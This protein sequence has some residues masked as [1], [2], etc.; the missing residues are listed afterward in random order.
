MVSSTFVCF[1]LP[2]I[3]VAVGGHPTTANCYFKPVELDNIILFPFSKNGTLRILGRIPPGSKYYKAFGGKLIDY[4]KVL[5]LDN[6]TWNAKF[7][8]LKP[9][10]TKNTTVKITNQRLFQRLES[11]LFL[12]LF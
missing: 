8:E 6:Y 4:T 10:A 1:V 11:Y 12:A 5:H 7:C 2:V 9:T 3:F